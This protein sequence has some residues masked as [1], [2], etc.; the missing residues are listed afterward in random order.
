M[1][2]KSISVSQKTVF[3]LLRASALLLV[4]FL[5]V[6]IFFFLNRTPEIVSTAP[7]ADATAV[8]TTA[9]FLF[10]FNTRLDKKTLESITISPEIPF[11]TE[12]HTNGSFLPTGT[13]LV[14]I[15]PTVVLERET[16]YTIQITTPKALY[17]KTGQAAKISVTTIPYASVQQTTPADQA[18]NIPVSQ[19]SYSIRYNVSLNPADIV[20]TFM[21]DVPFTPPVNISH[22]HNLQFLSPL[23]KNTTYTLT[24]STKDG[25]PY[26][27][28][29][30][31]TTSF[32]TEK[33]VEQVIIDIIDSGQDPVEDTP[34]VSQELADQ[35]W[36]ES[37][38]MS[39]EA[40]PELKV[41]NQLPIETP[42]YTMKYTIST[43]E[44]WV[45][46]KDPFEEN[47]QLAIDWLG[48]QGLSLSN[49]D[50]QATIIFVPA[51]PSKEGQY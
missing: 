40:D 26:L 50:M 29:T 48:K 31:I 28:S 34:A 36:V 16:T 51:S 39:I 1:A 27:F 47:R 17:G 2:I 12:I 15:V 3:F 19:S 25:V 6:Q 7:L 43:D 10:E 44:I 21:P 42:Y 37:I 33:T 11:T 45:F 24:I 8:D 32:T 20:Y 18:E 38:T 5:V 46:V 9:S 4:L 49:T 22:I 23:E 30:P 41:I 13:S 14:T 35:A